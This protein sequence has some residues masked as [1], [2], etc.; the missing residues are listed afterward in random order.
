MPKQVL[1]M[2]FGLTSDNTDHPDR[3]PCGSTLCLSVLRSIQA[4]KIRLKGEEGIWDPRYRS[5]LYT[6]PGHPRPLLLN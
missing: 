6:S 5:I 3:L 4:D 1:R 2:C